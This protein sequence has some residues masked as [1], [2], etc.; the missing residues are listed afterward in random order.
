ML[1]VDSATPSG[2][3]KIGEV[4]KVLGISIRT[5]HMYER[6]G[7]FIAYKNR[8]GTRYFSQQDI[9]WF[10]ELRKLIKSSISIAGI[11]ALLS[12]IP[13]WEVRQCHFLS[14]NNCPVIADQNSPCWANTEKMCQESGQECRE[15]AVYG[16]RFN[17]SR[18]KDVVD[19]KIKN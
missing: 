12:L 19:I 15:C 1:N 6:E 9:Q 13:C 8:S 5:I 7:L 17:V 10:V 3:V 18:L 4:A 2:M 11:R 14:R 16:L